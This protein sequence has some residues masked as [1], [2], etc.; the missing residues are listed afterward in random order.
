MQAFSIFGRYFS[1]EQEL[2]GP[3]VEKIVSTLTF[4]SATET[5]AVAAATE[6][7]AGGEQLWGILSPDT[8]GTRRR[9]AA[10]L[11][12][13]ANRV[14]RL[15][16]P[17]FPDLC[18]L[19]LQLMRDQRIFQQEVMMLYEVLVLVS[20]SMED[21]EQRVS[22]VGE[23]LREPLETWGGEAVGMALGRRERRY[24]AL[25]LELYPSSNC[26]KNLF[27]FDFIHPAKYSSSI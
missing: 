26:G 4:M 10:A 2:L 14:P 5:V 17:C 6:G 3:V 23:V 13:L 21:A 18:D 8:R 15:L 11:V 9:A 24:F 27:F 22:F 19:T 20:N 25:H 12:R 16:L 7:G 1:A